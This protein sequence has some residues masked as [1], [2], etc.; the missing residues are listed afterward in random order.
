MTQYAAAALPFSGHGPAATYH[1]AML[2]PRFDWRSIATL[3]LAKATELGRRAAAL[4]PPP[5]AV[6]QI[7][8]D[9]MHTAADHLRAAYRAL[10][11]ADPAATGAQ[12][13]TRLRLMVNGLEHGS[14]VDAGERRVVPR[15]NGQAP[16]PGRRT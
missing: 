1:E 16:Q 14:G 5:A 7:V 4:E 6:A 11:D 9:P 12:L 3:A 2:R 10:R 15:S 13:F 8:A